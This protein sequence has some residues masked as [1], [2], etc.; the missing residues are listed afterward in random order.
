MKKQIGLI[1]L[2]CLIIGGCGGGSAPAQATQASE[3]IPVP[4]DLAFENKAGDILY[5]YMDKA[6]AEEIL[7]DQYDIP[8]FGPR[9][10][11]GIDVG[12]S[13]DLVAY[14]SLTAED[15][16]KSLSGIHIGDDVNS[17]TDF[18]V[19]DFGKYFGAYRRFVNSKEY[20]RDDDYDF[21]KS[22]F[23]DSCSIE[24]M[25]SPH[26]DGDKVRSIS[27]YDSFTAKTAQFDDS[28]K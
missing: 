15:E 8:S 25:C 27:V 22:E 20:Q 4:K 10:Y 21:K 16:W 1:L 11:P 12:F 2:S 6:E 17:S 5:L 14:I 19:H 24:L 18:L 3:S 7:G 26:K 9:E 23:N 28:K 13:N